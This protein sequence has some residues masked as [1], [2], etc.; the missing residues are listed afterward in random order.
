M[1]TASLH[2]PSITWPF[3]MQRNSVRDAQS[4]LLT[5]KHRQRGPWPIVTV[6]AAGS[7]HVHVAGTQEQTRTSE[8]HEQVQGGVVGARMSPCCCTSWRSCTT[9]LMARETYVLPDTSVLC[10]Q[11][12]PS[13]GFDW[14][15]QWYPMAIAADLDPGRPHAVE[16]LGQPLV[17]A[18]CVPCRIIQAARTAPCGRL[19]AG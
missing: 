18:M 1:L 14:A 19:Q 15:K 10:V 11:A 3:L 8:S 16:L 12:A 9:P 17:G 5:S 13:G 2:K 6:S 7:N 4:E